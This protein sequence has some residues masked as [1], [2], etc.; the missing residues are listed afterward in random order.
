MSAGRW[1]VLHLQPVPKALRG[2]LAGSVARQV[3]GSAIGGP[4]RESPSAFSTSES[5]L[6]AT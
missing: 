3:E 6:S 4:S 5:V 1:D 2:K